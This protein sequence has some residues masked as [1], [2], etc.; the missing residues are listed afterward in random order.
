MKEPVDVLVIAA[1]PDDP[2]FGAAG[3]I[4]RMAGEGQKIAYVI[5]T[6]GE[7]GTGDRN[8]DPAE[9]ARIRQK[10]QRAAADTVGVGP[11]VFLHYPDQGLEDTPEF[12]KE[13]V[14][15][16]RTFRPR[17]VLSSDPYRRY[18]WH[19]DHRIVGQVVMD[20]LFPYARDHLA[21]PDLLAEG[22]EPHK[23]RE[24]WFWAAED[25]NHR[26]D[27]T[28][29]FETKIAALQ[30]H[31]SQWNQHPVADIRKWVED[32]CRKLAEGTSYTYAEGFHRVVLPE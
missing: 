24:A 12:R 22:L 10:E 21:Y 14:R 29:L 23:V 19:R 28:D 11:V 8:M 2:D 31:A 18:L 20:A 5:C 27:I 30:C 7:K 13:L 15:W 6:D 25:I 16:I 4:A 17:L 26:V 32:R 1:H 9:L 3:T